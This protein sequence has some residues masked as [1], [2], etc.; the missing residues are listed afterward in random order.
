MTTPVR[1]RGFTLLEVL[2]AIALLALLLT[3]A[4]AAMRTAIQASRS[5][6]A[7]IARSEEMR[8]AQA[9]LRRQFAGALPLAYELDATNGVQYLFE[10]GRDAI[11]FVAPMPGYLS[12]GG[13]HVQRLALVRAAGGGL[14]LEF[15]HSQLNGFDPEAGPVGG[16]REPVVLAT[17]ITD[18]GFE[19]RQREPDGR[20]G[21]WQDQ[22]DSPHALPQQL[23]LRVE[24]AADDGRHW[25]DLEVPVLA[26]GNSGFG[27]IGGNLR[28][29]G[30][31]RGARVPRPSE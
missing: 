29:P 6:E 27:A 15:N 1:P 8:T 26:A 2:V 5:G 3:L 7:L 9:F 22:W 19:F 12:R 23:R 25:P 20:L 10:G 16:D 30:E 14:Q 21:P 17:G 28:R 13:A 31:T 24:F 4:Y 18:G 11:Q